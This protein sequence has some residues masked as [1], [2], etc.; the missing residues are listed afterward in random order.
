MKKCYW[1]LMLISVI[2]CTFAQDPSIGPQTLPPPPWLAKAPDMSHWIITYSGSSANGLATPETGT[3]NGSGSPLK[4]KTAPPRQIE[5]TKTG[6][7]I[8]QQVTSVSAAPVQTWRTNGFILMKG[9]D[10]K[11]WFAGSIPPSNDL[12]NE[13]DYST[14]DFAGFNWISA[15]NFVG[16]QNIQG[17]KCLIFKDKVMALSQLDIAARKDEA[18]SSA[19]AEARKNPNGPPPPMRDELDMDKY[20]V[21]AEADIN[22]KTLL[23]VSLKINGN[24]R[25]YVYLPPPQAELQLPPDAQRALD[26]LQKKT[27][28]LRNMSAGHP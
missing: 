27:T 19:L 20:K 15:V 16:I 28:A 10:Q 26:D 2:T 1:M 23:P 4:P 3:P 21:D 24:T 17:V 14:T 25:T 8:L 11:N 9:L 5:V 12:F 13:A 18:N 6:T 7:T 22:L